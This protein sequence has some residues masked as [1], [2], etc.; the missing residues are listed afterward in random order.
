M[1]F[2]HVSPTLLLQAPLFLFFPIYYPF[3]DPYTL[4]VI[5]LLVTFYFFLFFVIFFGYLLCYVYIPFGKPSYNSGTLLLRIY[6]QSR[7]TI[8]LLTE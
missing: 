6:T 5:M 8:P 7:A 1:P 3:L 4:L 2:H